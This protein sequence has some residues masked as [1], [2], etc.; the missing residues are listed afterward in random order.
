MVVTA[1]Q[2]TADPR[3]DSANG[4]GVRMFAQRLSSS[5]GG[6]LPRQMER[7]V[8]A[9]RCGTELD[10]QGDADPVGRQKKCGPEPVELLRI[11]LVLPRNLSCDM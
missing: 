5:V 9:S 4:I 2:R 6:V 7:G 1:A 8:H 11:S 3:N 10:H